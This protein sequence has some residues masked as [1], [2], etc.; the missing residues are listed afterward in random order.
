MINYCNYRTMNDFA[1][2]LLENLSII[3]L[4]VL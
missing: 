2:K 3:G 1:F 4:T